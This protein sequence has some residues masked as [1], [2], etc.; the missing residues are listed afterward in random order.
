MPSISSASYTPNT[1][2]ADGTYVHTP[3]PNGSSETPPD[4]SGCS[5]ATAKALVST[6]ACSVA[7][8]AA[9]GSGGLATMAAAVACYN[10]VRDGI[11]AVHACDQ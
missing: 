2:A 1:C 7:T 9:V 10:A 4:T 6:L 5:A 3:G 11:D 8:A